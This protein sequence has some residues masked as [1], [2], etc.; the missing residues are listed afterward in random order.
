M[1]SHE[2]YFITGGN[3]GIGY[4]LVKQIASNKNNKVIASVR[5]PSSATPLIEL[6][7]QLGNIS[8]VTLDIGD[9]KDILNLSKQLAEVTDGIDVFISN[10]GISDSYYTI[11]DLPVDIWKEHLQVN[12][13]GPI[14]IFKQ[15]YPF[16]LKKD[17]RKV[18]FTSSLAGSIQDMPSL[19]FSA[20]GQSKAALNYVMKEL[21]FEVPDGF[22]VISFH[23]GMVSTDMGKLGLKILPE[24]KELTP[25][26][27]AESAK[28]EI[29]II[30]HLT[31]DD[32]GKFYS[33]DGSAI[34]F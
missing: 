25:I 27:P 21:S 17:T 1:S 6:N 19:S 10:A 12:T 14:L 31:R 3:R 9:E 34:L 8:V 32:N 33:Y 16:L 29:E 23:P 26:T 20:Y 15:V 28:S 2:T 18:V 24:L 7:K 11:L 4:E 5:K 22:K 30:N 13:L